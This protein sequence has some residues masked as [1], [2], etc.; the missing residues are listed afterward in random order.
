MKIRPIYPK[1][2]TDHS[3]RIRM[4][5]NGLNRIFDNNDANSDLVIAILA[6]RKISES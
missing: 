2:M 3:Q 1:W 6:S 5:S 4:I